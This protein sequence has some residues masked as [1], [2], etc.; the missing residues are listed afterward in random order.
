MALLAAI[1]VGSPVFAVDKGAVMGTLVKVEGSTYTIKDKK[2]VEKS[3]TANDTT[4]KRGGDAQPG[5]IV[6]LYLAKDG[7]TIQMVELI[8]K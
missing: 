2:G 6:E 4:K 3:Y 1:F 8:K 7:V 5:A